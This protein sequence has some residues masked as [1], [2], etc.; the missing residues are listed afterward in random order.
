M[1]FLPVCYQHWFAAPCLHIHFI[2][3]AT[4]IGCIFQAQIHTLLAPVLVISGNGSVVR[5][6]TRVPESYYFNYL[7]LVHFDLH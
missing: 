2:G 4:D 5:H 6:M 1:H 3:T 7:I